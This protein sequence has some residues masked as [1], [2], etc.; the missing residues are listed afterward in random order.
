MAN[1]FLNGKPIEDSFES[2]SLLEVVAAIEENHIPE[3]DIVTAVKV[4]GFKVM[5]FTH[6]DGTLVPYR[7]ESKVEISSE[8]LAAIMIKSLDDFTRYLERLLPGVRQI[9]AMFREGKHEDANA[10]YMEAMD[11]V[12]VM[13][14]LIQGMHKNELVDLETYRHGNSSLADLNNQLSGAVENMIRAQTEENYNALAE[15]IDKELHPCLEQWHG[16]MPELAGMLRKS[17]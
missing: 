2:T 8:K 17:E 10:L 12:K 16:V 9:A 6:E 5:Q 15:V 11:G 13:I 4:D 14:E 7:P 3:E 1:I